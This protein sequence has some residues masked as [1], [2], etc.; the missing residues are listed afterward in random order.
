MINVCYNILVSHFIFS[1]CGLT[2][3]YLEIVYGKPVS[4]V[5]GGLYFIGSFVQGLQKHLL[6]WPKIVY[7][8]PG[9]SYRKTRCREMN[10]PLNTGN[11]DQSGYNRKDVK[12]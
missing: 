8:G 6:K 10:K 12:I 11:I 1:R 2:T 9:Y 5:L 4:F 3:D 7:E